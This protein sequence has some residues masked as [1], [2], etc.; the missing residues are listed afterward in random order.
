VRQQN[1]IIRK[2]SDETVLLFKRG[3]RGRGTYVN[4][5]TS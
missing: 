3:I 1:K 2:I 5:V 4:S